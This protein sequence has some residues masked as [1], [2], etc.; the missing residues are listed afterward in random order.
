[1]RKGFFYRLISAISC[2][3]IPA[4]AQAIW[5]LINYF[6]A[7]VSTIVSVTFLEDISSAS[8]DD[9]L[10]IEREVYR[11]N[12][13]LVYTISAV[14]AIFIFYLVYKRFNI[15]TLR[16]LVSIKK[17]GLAKPIFIFVAGVLLN[18]FSVTAVKILSDIIPQKWI[19]ANSESVG[20][21]QQ[22][23]MFFSFLTIMIF[24]PIIEEILFRGLLY[25]SL[26]KAF[27]QIFPLKEK[28]IVVIVLC[29]LITSFCFGYIHGNILQ[30]IYTF[31][32]SLI[33]IYV[34][35]YTES[36]ISSIVMHIG[37]NMSMIF[38]QFLYGRVPD[39]VLCIVSIILSII[40]LTMMTI[41][42]GGKNEKTNY[43]PN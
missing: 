28:N 43:T 37:F 21:Y 27:C 23:S 8:A 17:I 32:L 10:I 26:K 34:I 25:S 30:G 40:A 41:V 22:G 29:A 18:V 19:D 31:V 33:M 13:S 12:T 42:N 16:D 1:M 7:N 38:T 39:I 20:V 9:L 14:I 36:I 15:K 24:A 6:V 5:Y 2:L 35:E 11:R 4:L 3:L